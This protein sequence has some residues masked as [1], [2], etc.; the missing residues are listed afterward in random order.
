MNAKLKITIGIVFIFLCFLL[1]PIFNVWNNELFLF[2]LTKYQ[3]F[4]GVFALILCIL[5]IDLSSLFASIFIENNKIFF[6]T[7]ILFTL[8]SSIAICFASNITSVS[9]EIT[10]EKG[11]YAIGIVNVILFLFYSSKVFDAT[12]FSINDMV[13]IALFV[14]IGF[15]LDISIFKIR[16]GASGGSISFVMVPLVILALRKD[17]VKSFMALGLVYGLINC[18]TDGYGFVT[19]PFDYL[20]GF[21]SL[22]VISLFRNKILPSNTTRTTLRGYLLLIVGCLLG[23]IGR[24]FAATLSGMLIYKLQFVPSLIYQLTY[25]GPSAG[26]LIGCLILLYKPLLVINNRYNNK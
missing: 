15:I 26:I 8:A 6:G 18:L 17:F 13:E 4:V 7:F 3:C 24:L 23:L 11:I 16:V 1:L 5:I 25:L 22:A 12:S 20:L 14:A 9:S 21:G 2:D 19:Y 10:Y